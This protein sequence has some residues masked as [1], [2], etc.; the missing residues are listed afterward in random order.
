MHAPFFFLTKNASRS[1]FEPS[2]PSHLDPRNEGLSRIHSERA[3][4]LL[5]RYADPFNHALR[6]ALLVSNR[7]YVDENYLYEGVV[8]T[9]TSNY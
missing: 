1:S 5:P 9:T 3:T 4:D 6:V 7:V 8:V 2:F